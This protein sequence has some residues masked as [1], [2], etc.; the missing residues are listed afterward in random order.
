M[1]RIKCPA[2]HRSNRAKRK[3]C[4]MCGAEI[5]HLRGPVGPSRMPSTWSWPK[6]GTRVSVTRSDHGWFDGRLEGTLISPGV[7]REDDGSEHEINHPR[8][9][10]PK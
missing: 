1:A 4:G 6:N 2:C 3:T 8:D 9:I 7:V 5:A 10:H